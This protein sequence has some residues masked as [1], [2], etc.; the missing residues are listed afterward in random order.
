[1]RRLDSPAAGMLQWGNVFFCVAKRTIDRAAVAGQDVSEVAEAAEADLAKAEAKYGE[2]RRI[3]PNYYD[4]FISMGNVE[5]ERA[6]LGLSFAVPPPQCAALPQTSRNT[7]CYSP[8]HLL[9]QL[10]ASSAWTM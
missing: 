10:N 1:M 2:S 6:K 7:L 3:K 5:F 8:S 4:A 9:T